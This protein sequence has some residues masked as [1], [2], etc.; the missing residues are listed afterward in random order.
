MQLHIATVIQWEFNIPIFLAGTIVIEE[1]PS[2][3]LIPVNEIGVLSCAASCFPSQCVGRWKINGDYTHPY[4]EQPSEMF[5]NLGF[6]FPPDQT[7]GNK[8]TMTLMVNAS[9]AVNNMTIG[10]EFEISIHEYNLSETATL[11]V[12]SGEKNH[13]CQTC[14]IKFTLFTISPLP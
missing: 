7:H 1:Q 13:Y 6:I 4:N 9:E 10:C 5:V 14:S 12:I 3:L 8:R 11:L 2:S